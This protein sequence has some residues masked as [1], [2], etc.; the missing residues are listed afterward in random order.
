M[1]QR[2]G[3]LSLQLL[4][5]TLSI[6]PVTLLF[7]PFELGRA[8]SRWLLAKRKIFGLSAA[9]Y[10]LIHT[11]LYL[12]YISWDWQLAWLEGLEWPFATGWIA[13]LLF[14]VIA[15]VSHKKGIATLGSWWKPIQRLSYAV[16]I[17]GFL[18]WLLLD[19]F[20][21][22]AMEWIIPLVITK[23][24]HIGFRINQLFTKPKRPA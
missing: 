20:I 18:H 11:V 19:F 9:V 1:M 6:T 4:V 2:S 14:V 13:L 23:T 8:I 21:H 10:A 7:K 15:S 3:V 12:R 22:D 5:L 16:A 24:V 17:F